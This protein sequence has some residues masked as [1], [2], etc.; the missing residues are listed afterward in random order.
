MPDIF[1]KTGSGD[2]PSTSGKKA[3]WL[4]EIMNSGQIAYARDRRSRANVPA[5]L[6]ETT[7]KIPIG[8]SKYALNNSGASVLLLTPKTPPYLPKDQSKD[9][10]Q[11]PIFRNDPEKKIGKVHESEED[12]NRRWGHYRSGKMC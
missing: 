5:N 3:R 10:P 8:F 9:I 7:S 1:K 2:L 11:E 12:K 6:F 4:E